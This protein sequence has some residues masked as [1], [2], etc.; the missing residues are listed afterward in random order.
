MS[1][2][3]ANVEYVS[4]GGPAVAGAIYRAAVTETMPITA[5][6]ALDPTKFKT[7]GYISEDGYTNSNTRASDG[8][9][10]WDGNEI[11]SVQTEK[12][13]TF[14]YKML[15][16]MNEEVLKDVYGD[17][18]VSGSLANGLHIKANAKELEMHAYVIDVRLNGG[19]IKRTV[20]PKGKI[21]E[22]A[23]TVHKKTEAL[24]F[25]VTVTAYPS[26]TEGNTHHEYIAAEDESES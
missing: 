11:L 8:I 22:I 13:D 12:K 14:K 3:V 15:E 25:E 26:D 1:T 17:N 6:E 5:T 10:D 4:T 20:I 19:Y 24:G 2:N 21:T 18:N 9:K 23:D 16:V 7:L